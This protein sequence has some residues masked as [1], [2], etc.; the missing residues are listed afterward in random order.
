M[1]NFTRSC[2]RIIYLRTRWRRLIIRNNGTIAA[3]VAEEERT[4]MNVVGLI[5]RV[6]EESIGLMGEGCR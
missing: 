2:P 5:G 1:Q 3:E 6:E 4:K